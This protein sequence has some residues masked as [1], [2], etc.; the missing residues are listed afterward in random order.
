MT[1][2]REKKKGEDMSG[3]LRIS[4]SIKVDPD[5]RHAFVFL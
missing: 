3:P 4:K 1:A 2:V 5:R